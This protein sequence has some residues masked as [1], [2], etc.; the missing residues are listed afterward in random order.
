MGSASEF[1][2]LVTLLAHTAP[3]ELDNLRQKFPGASAELR[4]GGVLGGSSA[5]VGCSVAI[6]ALSKYSKLAKQLLPRLRRRLAWSWRFD[7]VAKFAAA[8]GSGGTV[9]A[10]VAGAD[11]DKT[12]IA[13]VV[14]LIGS[15][16]SLV[17]AYLQRDVAAGSVPD[18]Y[19]RL[20]TALVEAD[21]LQRTLPRLC[22]QGTSP[23]LSAALE[24]AN[25][26]AKGLNELSIRFA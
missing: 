4:P 9:G 6:A 7:L 21:D 25:E 17:F 15:V 26:T 19:N 16:C 12:V 13:A 2:E 1:G 11:S 23:E 22:A 3:E 20:I 8:F 10:L 5:D 24:K 14:A 18:S